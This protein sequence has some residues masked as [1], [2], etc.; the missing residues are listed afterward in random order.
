MTD[1]GVKDS[2]ARFRAELVFNG[3]RSM[4]GFVVREWS[5]LFPEEKK[6]IMDIIELADEGWWDMFVKESKNEARRTTAE[7]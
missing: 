2:A 7:G 5:D 3:L 6:R 1:E 4:F